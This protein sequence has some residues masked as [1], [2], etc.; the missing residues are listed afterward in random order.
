MSICKTVNRIA[1]ALRESDLPWLL[2]N[3]RQDCVI[4]EALND[5]A[6]LDKVIQSN[7]G[8]PA[9]FSPASLSLLALGRPDLSQM[10]VSQQLNAIEDPVVQLAIQGVDERAALGAAVQD[11]ASAGLVA[12][13]WLNKHAVTNSWKGLLQAVDEHAQQNWMAY[14]A[15]LFGLL[16]DPIG[17][18]HALVRPGASQT[19]LELAVHIIL[20]NPL[21]T[22]E[23]V[24]ILADLCHGEFGDPLPPYDRL[25]LLQALGGQNSQLASEFSIKWMEIHPDLPAQLALPKN[26]NEQLRCLLENLFQIEIRHTA[27]A[28]EG[29]AGLLE[30]EL[31]DA[32]AIFT[33]LVSHYFKHKHDL[34]TE[35]T[36]Q[37]VGADIYDKVIKLKQLNFSTEAKPGDYAELALALADSGFV[38]VAMELIS[39]EDES[40][41][42]DVDSLF[43]IAKLSLIKGDEGRCWQT[44]SRILT[45]LEHKSGWHATI[46]GEGFSLVT[47]GR[48]LFEIHKAPE[49]VQVLERALRAR[50]ND[51]S[52]LRLLADSYQSAHLGYKAAD[53]LNTL[54]LLEPAVLEYRRLHAQA[55]EAV[56]EWQASLD[57]RGQII[58]SRG[59]KGDPSYLQDQYDYA[60][61]A[62]NAA[63]PVLALKICQSI[64]DQNQDDSQALIFIGEAHLLMDET[65]QALECLTRATQIA[66]D[67]SEVWLALAGAQKKI[68]P[69]NTVIETLKH[70]SLA[71]PSS[72]QIRYALGDAFVQDS[73]L[74]IALPELQCAV[75]LSPDEPQFLVRYGEAL[76][77]LGHFEA[78]REIFSKAF[79]LAPDFPGL[80]LGYAKLLVELGKL[81]EALAPYEILV[82]SKTIQEPGPYLDYARCVLTLNKQGGTTHPAMKALVALNQ[83]LQMDPLHAEAKALTAEALAANGESELAFRAYRDALESPLIEN[84]SWFE[85]L[86]FGLGCVASSMGKQDVAIAALQDASQVNPNNPDIYKALSDAYIAASLPE[87]ALRSARSV[88]VIDETNPDHL[89]WF[90]GQVAKLSGSKKS[91]SFSTGSSV[92]KE[93][94]TEALSALAS[95]IE[96]APTRTDLLVQLGNFQSSIGALAEAQ[97]TFA[98]IASFAFATIEDLQNAAKY[99]SEIGD[100]LSAISCLEKGIS[101]AINA[102]QS[103]D[104]AIYTC[105]AWEYVKNQDHISALNTLD[106]AIE[107]MPGEG[108][109]IVLKV[110][111]LLGLGKSQEALNVIEVA[112][113]N[114]PE[115]GGNV[116]LL[117]LASLINRSI[118]NFPA[119]VNY[120]QM[121][122]AYVNKYITERA[123]LKLINQH[124]TQIAEIYRALLQ[125]ECAFQ[126]LQN[127]YN[128]N[129]PDFS[130]EQQFLD[131]ILLHTELALVTGGRILQDIQEVKLE[132]P[133]PYFSRL[134]AINA[135]LMNKAGNYK[136]AEQLFQLALSKM[137]DPEDQNGLPDWSAAHTKYLNLVGIIEAAQDLGLWDQSMAYAQQL[138][139]MAPGEPLSQVYLASTSILRA[140][141]IQLCEL[142]KVTRHI[143][144]VDPKSVEISEL[145]TRYLDQARSAL[146]MYQGKSIIADHE[147]N[148]DQILRWQA[149]SNIIF[150]K[151]GSAGLDLDEI[152][153]RQVLPGDIAAFISHLRRKA[154]EDTEGDNLTQIIQV[155]R[156]F[157]RHPTVILQVALALEE[158]N[159]QEAMRSLQS[160]LEHN[161]YSRNSSIAFCNLLLAQIALAQGECE[162][163]LQAVEKAISFWPDE[164]AWHLLAAHIYQQANTIDTAIQ[165]LKEAVNLTP[166]NLE[167]QLELGKVLSDNANADE[168]MYAQALDSFEKALA[169]DPK[170]VSVL[171]YLTDTNYRLNDLDKAEAY[172]RQALSLSPDRV[173]LYLQMSKIA[174]DK[175]DFQGAYEHAGKAIQADPMDAQ[176]TV[177][178]ARSLSAMGRYQEALAKLDTAITILQ[179]SR[180]LH[181]ERVN[182]LRTVSGPQVA[183][184]ELRTLTNRYP[185][186]FEILNVLTKSFYEAGDLENA[187][188][189]ARRALNAYPEKTSPNEQASLHL[190]I[191]QALRQSGDLDQS[192]QYLSAAIQQAPNRLEPYLE[193]GQARKARREYQQ[194]LHIF[195]QATHVAPNDPRALFQAGLAFKESKDYKSSETML[196]RAVSL[197]PNDLSIRRQLAAVVALNLIHNPRS[198][199]TNA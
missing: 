47:L 59:I 175:N 92:S 134:M 22:P 118:G 55:L 23:Q 82:D 146:V 121:G 160:V 76:R 58:A 87:D 60:R 88:L 128:I 186:D 101:I 133:H 197:A 11:L 156:P 26:P 69:L 46:W 188:A 99:L 14:L 75:E 85:R 170:N 52:L 20:S 199:R 74:T 34:Q 139:D 49:A 114:Q 126:F 33:D 163:A 183:L 9:D 124:R 43:A 30:A 106:K 159:P 148:D 37:G 54:V 194:A 180:A 2:A 15:C 169:V 117:F 77:L 6:F 182:I 192:I 127:G 137:I 98:S 62:I 147:V 78:S 66:P 104:P 184:N 94:V 4:W 65:D 63:E 136:Q 24:T 10:A 130:N 172:A 68:Y 178:L 110:E 42:D 165:H 107:I 39:P 185:D 116:D 97:A 89:A 81:E 150:D 84:K 179:E 25:A 35:K 90:A 191:G 51:A 57:E 153:T 138:A 38:D 56:G 7:P 83:V 13:S 187:I 161:P 158:C 176:A 44:A 154:S 108:S 174:L 144:F 95:A 129:R 31:S 41:L 113:E 115:A 157:P 93:V 61:C 32:Q 141:F 167:Y 123:N 12:I 28:N 152:L 64:L 105:L 120:A 198:A 193:L 125:P 119:C 29:L 50:P 5:P 103:H 100:H 96:L 16:D 21:T 189:V 1:E 112:L 143:P 151:P 149:R 190:L 171:V 91:E 17:L 166:G 122:L 131:F 140:E 102:E 71:V 195:E 19:Q 40:L 111:I 162:I 109:L 177:M 48:L 155:A 67:R 173:D 132:T 36:C 181:L 142:F 168:S 70:A 164:P 135:R 145:C 18:L 86:S 53:V 73:Q 79:R 45:L 196:R 3:L 8:K 72:A 27:S 80:A